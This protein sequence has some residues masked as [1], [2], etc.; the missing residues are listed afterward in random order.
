MPLRALKAAVR[1]SIATLQ[2]G[3]KQGLSQPTSSANIA[4]NYSRRRFFAIALRRCRGEPVR[5]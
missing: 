5:R 2:R 3:R 1:P 4:K